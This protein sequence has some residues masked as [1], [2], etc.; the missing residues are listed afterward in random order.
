M[1]DHNSGPFSDLWQLGAHDC[2]KLNLVV[3]IG[4]CQANLW[5]WEAKA[6]NTGPRWPPIP[7]MYTKA[8]RR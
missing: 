8:H 6:N 3:I 4:V 2:S 5:K 1:T 7:H